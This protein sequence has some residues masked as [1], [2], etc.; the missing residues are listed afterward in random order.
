MAK[1]NASRF[2]A[3]DSG[4]VAATYALGLVA[5]IAIAG[6]G[7][8]YAR[9]AGMHSELQNAADQAALAGATQLDQQPD[10][11]YRAATAARSLL[12][13]ETLL[14]RV[15]GGSLAVN[16]PLAIDCSGYDERASGGGAILFWQDAD[17]TT[18]A[19]S[20]TNASFIEVVVVERTADYALTPIVGLFDSGGLDAGATAG[21]GSSVCEVPPLMICMPQTGL[22]SLVPGIGIEATS[23]TAGNSWGPGDFGFLEVGAGTNADLAKAIAYQEVPLDCVPADGTNPETG[24]AQILYEAINTRMDIFP[25]GNDAPLNVCRSGTCTVAS[26]TVKDV[27]NT[28]PGSSDN[29]CRL[30]NQGWQLP[31]NRFWP[32]QEVLGEEGGAYPQD[33]DDAIDAMG[34]SRDLCHYASYVGSGD[35]NGDCRNS[36]GVIGRDGSYTSADRFGDGE[37]PRA[38]YFAVNHGIIT[39]P[40]TPLPVALQSLTRYQTYLWEQG[41]LTELGGNS[42]PPPAATNPSAIFGQRT[43]AH[44]GVPASSGSVDRRTLTVA[45]VTNCSSLAGGSTSVQVGGWYDMFLVEPVVDDNTERANGRGNDEVYL[46]VIR[47]TTIGTGSGAGS[48]A[49]RRDVPYLVR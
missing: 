47:P 18:E 35:S 48:Q 10:A 30:G 20:Y 6:V 29:Q 4:A 1:R 38:D 19:N 33:E 40:T 39:T 7:Y 25:Q 11:C 49:V 28:S 43:T 32:R 46:E 17:K 36:S 16:V 3:N 21:V 9:M 14:G 42:L 13:N 15:E 37:W 45:V 23:H 12:T 27:V 8:D 34:Y 31:T 26:N 2:L 41:L 22:A 24:N 44:C 5:L